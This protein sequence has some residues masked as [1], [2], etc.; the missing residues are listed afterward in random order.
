MSS[1]RSV[2]YVAGCSIGPA[3]PDVFMVITDPDDRKFAALSA[4]ANRPLVTSDNHLLSQRN[5]AGIEVLT[6][7]EFLART[8]KDGD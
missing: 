2:T 5:T 3:H 7:A 8:E 1:V 4:A 6:P